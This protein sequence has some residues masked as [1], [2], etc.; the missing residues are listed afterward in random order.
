LFVE[1][2]YNLTCGVWRFG[3]LTT[4]PPDLTVMGNLTWGR[5][6]GAPSMST[7]AI[8]DNAAFTMVLLVPAGSDVRDVYSPPGNDTVEAPLGSGRFYYA[9]FVDDIGKGFS[10]EHRAVLLVKLGPWPAPIP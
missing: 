1:P 8:L 5:R 4:G 2:T 9:A 6:V 7:A 3:S 10:N